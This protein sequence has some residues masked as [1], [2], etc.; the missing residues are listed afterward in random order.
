L[1]IILFIWAAIQTYFIYKYEQ[2]VYYK[3]YIHMSI[4]LALAIAF[5]QNV[6]VL[7]SFHELQ[8]FCEE[9]SWHFEFTAYL[10]N[11]LQWITVFNHSGK[12]VENKFKIAFTILGTLMFCCFVVSSVLMAFNPHS[13]SAFLIG[14]VIYTITIIG[15]TFCI[16][17]G[18]AVYGFRIA[19]VL[20]RGIVENNVE[21]DRHYEYTITIKTMILS[22]T[23]LI[24]ALTGCLFAIFSFGKA[25]SS[26]PIVIS[27]QVYQ[28][29]IIAEILFIQKP[30][31]PVYKA[32]TG[33]L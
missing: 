1:V 29:I 14:A 9:F 13:S 8:Q 30:K 32:S 11:L 19:R 18:F 4:L 21:P 24:G 10:L 3:Q 33:S 17:T 26:D 6:S 16:S 25:G 7:I 2:A 12:L 28:V 22:L 31:K 23:N 20:R 5:T 27:S 15:V